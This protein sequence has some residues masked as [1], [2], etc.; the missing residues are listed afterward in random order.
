MIKRRAFT[1]TEIAV[2]ILILGVM[3]AGIALNTNISKQ[4][5]K[6]EAE[7]VYVFISR[8]IERADRTQ[9]AF[10]LDVKEDRLEV[11]TGKNY[12]TAKM[13]N[14]FNAEGGCSF[15]RYGSPKKHMSYNVPSAQIQLTHQNFDMNNVKIETKSEPVDGDY[16]IQVKSTG[17][18]SEYYVVLHEVI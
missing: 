17:T 3:A 4:T 13:K 15:S 16:N 12:G 14:D 9:S 11:R 6:S 7:R 8:L 18:S 2:S 1:L 5:A 10:W